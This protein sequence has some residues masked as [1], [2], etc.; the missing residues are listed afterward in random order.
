MDCLVEFNCSVPL[1]LH[2]LNECID[3]NRHYGYKLQGEYA[4][5]GVQA[6]RLQA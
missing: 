6:I 4:T 1:I 3:I 5:T 2:Q